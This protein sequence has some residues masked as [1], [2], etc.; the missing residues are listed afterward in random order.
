[1]NSAMG[2]GFGHCRR[3]GLAAAIAALLAMALPMHANPVNAQTATAET[4][5]IPDPYKLN[6]LIR[7]TLI[8]LN[9]ANRTG[10]YTVLRDLSAPAFARTNDAA[11]LAEIFAKLRK[12]GLDISP[13][14]FFQPK[15]RG[16]AKL[17]DNGL[18]R[19]TGYFE[20]KPEQISFD[21]L[22]QPVSG[23]WLLFGLAV[24][25][26]PPKAAEEKPAASSDE[27][28]SVEP[29]VKRDRAPLPR[30][31]S[32]PAPSPR[33]QTTVKEPAQQALETTTEE[34]PQEDESS[35]SIWSLWGQ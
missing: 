8:A 14:L 11:K 3:V 15:L 22:F 2:F 31:A 20:T 18:L 34:K 16:P 23:N 35:G 12:R 29:A 30:K 26:A 9:H 25:V 4:P 7:T 1:M 27:R 32:V 13:I 21:M 24:D 19:L 33:P 28:S 10:N 6:M 5:K 17:T